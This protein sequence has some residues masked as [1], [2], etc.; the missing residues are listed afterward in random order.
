MTQEP[1]DG[2]GPRL[3]L[4]RMTFVGIRIRGPFSVS[5]CAAMCMCSPLR[6]R[7]PPD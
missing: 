5:A 1:L 3:Y 6:A 7:V 2:R 4:R